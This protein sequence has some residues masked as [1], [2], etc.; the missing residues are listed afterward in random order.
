MIKNRIINAKCITILEETMKILARQ[1]RKKANYTLRQL[2]DIL[3]KDRTGRKHLNRL[4]TKDRRSV[5]QR[6]LLE[7]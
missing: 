7:R 1:M 2:A 6:D 5:K 4:N 3:E